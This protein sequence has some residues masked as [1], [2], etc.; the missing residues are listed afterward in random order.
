MNHLQR[1][2]EGKNIQFYKGNIHH[3]LYTSWNAEK[4]TAK[5][6]TWKRKNGFEWSEDLI[7]RQVWESHFWWSTW[8]LDLKYWKY[9]WNVPLS[10][11]YCPSLT[12]PTLRKSNGHLMEEAC[13]HSWNS[14]WTPLLVYQ[15]PFFSSTTPPMHQAF[16]FFIFLHICSK[17]A[18]A[19]KWLERKDCVW[20]LAEVCAGFPMAYLYLMTSQQTIW[21]VAQ[22]A[23]QRNG[24]NT[25]FPVKTLG[26]ML[27]WPQLTGWRFVKEAAKDQ[28][29]M[30]PRNVN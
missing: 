25:V 12:S 2:Y 29:S 1:G 22:H 28:G 3:H 11:L 13:W 26:M 15:C 6:S 23:M 7:V 20:L 27:D 4:H 18:S 30:V 10:N 14:S 24:S 5:W 8:N 19:I 21:D 17:S 16:A 9:E